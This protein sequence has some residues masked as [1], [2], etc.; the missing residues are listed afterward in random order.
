MPPAE[1]RRDSLPGRGRQPH[2][3]RLFGRRFGWFREPEPKQSRCPRA[4]SSA[5]AV[6]STQ[7][8]R[9]G[10]PIATILTVTR[11]TA[12]PLRVEGGGATEPRWTIGQGR[13]TC[14]S[15][16]CPCCSTSS[17][18]FRTPQAP[19][20]S[21]EAPSWSGLGTS[22]RR[23]CAGCRSQSLTDRQESGGRHPLPNGLTND[24]VTEHGRPQ[25]AL[26]T[27]PH[28]SVARCLAC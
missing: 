5:G 10:S 21:A 6:R 12:P 20:R 28:P 27:T 2:L 22:C 3:V 4:S 8:R 11:P 16:R 9:P 7:P 1:L 13:A 18:R 17:T 15:D 24:L 26:S 19:S 23:R 25:I 14:S